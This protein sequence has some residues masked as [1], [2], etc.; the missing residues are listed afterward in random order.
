M[1]LALPFRLSSIL[2]RLV[3][4]LPLNHQL[5]GANGLNCTLC[6]NSTTP[7]QRVGQS[8]RRNAVVNSTDMLE[9]A[10]N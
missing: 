6:C 3:R 9:A 2:R 1:L 8:P 10:K 5:E 7:V 4:K